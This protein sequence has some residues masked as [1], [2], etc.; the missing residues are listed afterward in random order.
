MQI[1][2][3]RPEHEPQ[4]ITL[5]QADP[6]WQSFVVEPAIDEFRSALLSSATYVLQDDHAV[7]GYV[8]AMTDAFGIYVSELYVAPRFRNLGHGRQL[9]HRVKSE[10]AGKPVYV[11]SDEDKYYEKLGL[12]RVGS[13]FQL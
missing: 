1:D 9:L 3:Y 4:L 11:L 6:D 7:C 10:N 2:Q 12:K 13:V 5:L 8:R